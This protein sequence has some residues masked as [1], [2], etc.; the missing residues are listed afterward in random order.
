MQRSSCSGTVPGSFSRRAAPRDPNLAHKGTEAGGA[1][2]QGQLVAA[3]APA[4]IARLRAYPAPA[5]CSDSFKLALARALQAFTAGRRS[6]RG[7]ERPTNQRSGSFLGLLPAGR[8]AALLSS[9]RAPAPS[10]PRPPADQLAARSA[11]RR[12][13]L[14]REA[15][16]CPG[17]RRAL[18]GSRLWGRGVAR[19]RA[20]L[21]GP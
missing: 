18:A 3:L 10:P 15:H 11:A 1:G 7:S 4:R 2:L 9:A 19:V 17:L 20:G 8:A 21:A 5:A 14:A 12:V 16:E 13:S 6:V